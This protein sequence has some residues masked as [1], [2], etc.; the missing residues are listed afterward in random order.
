[1]INSL[2]YNT[3]GTDQ[4]LVITSLLYTI[5]RQKGALIRMTVL[6]LV[7]IA[8]V[9]IRVI[10]TRMLVIL[11]M[12][13]IPKQQVLKKCFRKQI[14]DPPSPIKVLFVAKC[15]EQPLQN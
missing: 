9:Y 5:A 3:A 14:N 7:D 6:P 10:N 1:M 13:V 11:I 8:L 15:I 4:G 2:L 12:S